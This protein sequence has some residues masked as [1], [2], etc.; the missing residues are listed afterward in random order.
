MFNT[1]LFKNKLNEF[2]NNL[3]PDLTKFT[4]LKII[5]K[6]SPE[7]KNKTNKRLFYFLNSNYKEILYFKYYIRIIIV[8]KSN[9]NEFIKKNITNTPA[10][11]NEKDNHIEIG[12][13]NVINYII[14]ICKFDDDNENDDDNCN[15]NYDNFD[16]NKITNNKISDV[17]D[18]LLDEIFKSDSKIE[19]SLDLDLVREKEREYKLINEKRNNKNA[20]YNQV[21]KNHNNEIKHKFTINDK[22]TKD[23]MEHQNSQ[24]ELTEIKKN[25]KYK[26]DNDILNMMMDDEETI[27]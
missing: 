8:D 25:E 17:N 19:D 15:N 26:S 1:N 7:K 24:S 4:I 10:L 13:T 12:V 5:V 20:Q 2:S 18:Y 16:N 23:L 27:L 6:D 14:N 11:I 9:C 3:L 22:E 21:L